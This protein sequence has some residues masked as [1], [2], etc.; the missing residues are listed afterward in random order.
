MYVRALL[1]AALI[2]AAVVVPAAA[3]AARTSSD[4]I[5]GYQYYATSTDGK[6]VGAASGA[7][8]GSWNAEVQHTAL[9][10]SCATTATIT[11]GSFLLTTIRNGIPTLI[12]GSFAGGTVQVTNKG[13]NCTNRTFAVDGIL[14]R[15]GTWYSGSGTGSFN[16]T[17]THYRRSIFGN[18]VT[19]GAS[20]GGSLTVTF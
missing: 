9:C 10:L 11:G 20:V 7:L 17:L 2:A 16:I 8:P 18:C 1:I 19:Y 4:T 6:F 13:T 12:T 14:G 5:V 3:L 15:V